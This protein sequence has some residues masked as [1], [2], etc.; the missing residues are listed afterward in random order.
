[1]D[2]WAKDWLEEQRKA[3]KKCLEIKV[4]ARHKII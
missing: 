3:G 1:M 4:R 2:T